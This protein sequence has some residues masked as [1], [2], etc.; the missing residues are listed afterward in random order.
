MLEPQVVIFHEDDIDRIIHECLTHPS[1]KIMVAV[2]PSKINN[3]ALIFLDHINPTTLSRSLDYTIAMQ[4]QIL[5][6]ELNYL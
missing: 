2:K 4:E 5:P 1:C 3:T 6:M